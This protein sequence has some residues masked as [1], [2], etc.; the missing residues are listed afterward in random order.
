MVTRRRV[1]PADAV[2]ARDGKQC[3]R[4]WLRRNAVA[5]AQLGPVCSC[6]PVGLVDDQLPFPIR[7]PFFMHIA[8]Q[9]QP[10]PADPGVIQAGGIRL[11]PVL[12][13][14]Q[15]IA[16]FDLNLKLRPTIPGKASINRLMQGKG[17]RSSSRPTFGKAMRP[18]RQFPQLGKAA[19]TP[20]TFVQQLPRRSLH[21]VTKLPS[22]NCRPAV[23]DDQHR[24]IVER[25]RR[26]CEVRPG[27]LH[28]LSPTCRGMATSVTL[29]SPSISNTA[30]SPFDNCAI[31]L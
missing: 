13:R 11:G 21:G 8:D 16:G 19:W 3:K 23:L 9:S 2:I 1:H 28:H 22:L 24:I 6:L 10:V 29:F 7:F 4:A 15:T 20:G 30:S 12:V 17:S 27:D 25:E 14:Q 5:D 31:R 26:G 18:L